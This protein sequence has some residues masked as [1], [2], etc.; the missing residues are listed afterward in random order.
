M[1]AIIL[2]VS[3]MLFM[4]PQLARAATEHNDERGIILPK[5]G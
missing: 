3:M 4:L 5:R 2:V 1:I